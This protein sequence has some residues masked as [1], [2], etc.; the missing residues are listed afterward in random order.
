MQDFR[1]LKRL[2]LVAVW[3]EVALFTST[4]VYLTSYILEEDIDV[5][6]EESVSW[7][8]ILAGLLLF[9]VPDLVTVGVYAHLKWIASK[10]Q[11]VWPQQQQEAA[12]EDND[13]DRDGYVHGI[14]VGGGVAALPIDGA[15]V[16]G[17]V[18]EEHGSRLAHDMTNY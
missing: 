17:H 11:A 9:E 3:L 15:V 8:R 16:P 1:R 6:M 10:K 14:Y 18:E 4:F 5:L 2:S 7:S 13:E 12:S